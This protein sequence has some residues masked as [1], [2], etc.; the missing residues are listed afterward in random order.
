MKITYLGQAGLLLET[1]G[2][3][4]LV[5]P[6]LSDSVEKVNPRNRRRAAVDPSF[7]KLRPD[8]LLCTHNHLDHLDP[9]TLAHYFTPEARM[10]VLAPSGSW[11]K[12]RAY[13]GDSNYVLF[14]RHTEWTEDSIRFTAVR[15]VHSDP[16]AIGVIVAAEG[17]RWYIS[18]DTLYSRE[19]LEDLSGPFEAVFLPVNGAGNNMN[20][21]DAA[22]L[23]AQLDAKYVVPIHIGLFDGLK[24][25]D[26]P[27]PNRVLAEIYREI[28]FPEE[29]NR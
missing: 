20:M 26:F 19:L 11:E 3:S 12:L 28:R 24:G 15:A 16:G 29:E 21:A 5:D 27:A 17:K 10:T 13:G 14:D 7:L 4:I 22:R 2:R 8:V 25:E 18:G 1:G 6:Y 9:E 23:A